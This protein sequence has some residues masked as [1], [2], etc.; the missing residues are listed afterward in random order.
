MFTWVKNIAINYAIKL[1]K[2]ELVKI[3]TNDPGMGTVI[4]GLYCSSISRFLTDSL[5]TLEPGVATLTPIQLVKKRIG[6]LRDDV[7]GIIIKV[8][9]GLAP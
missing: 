5:N 7:E 4:D 9:D 2:A 8:L 3:K 1:I 6:P